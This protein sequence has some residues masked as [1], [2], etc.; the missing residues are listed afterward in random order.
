MENFSEKVNQIVS[1]VFDSLIRQI[2]VVL[3]QF[4]CDYVVLSGK[5]ASLE[6][7]ENIFRKYLTASPSNIINLNNLLG[8]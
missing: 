6:S 1:S 7:F 4:Q 8:R 2:S 3:N 5:P